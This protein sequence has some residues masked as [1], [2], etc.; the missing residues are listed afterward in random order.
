MTWRSMYEPPDNKKRK[1]TYSDTEDLQAPSWVQTMSEANKQK[2]QVLA[3]ISLD[4]AMRE[5][6]S[7]KGEPPYRE[8]GSRFLWACNADG[9]IPV[10]D[11]EVAF[12]DHMRSVHNTDDRRM[13]NLKWC[14]RRRN[15]VGDIRN[16]IRQGVMATGH[17][18]L[19]V[20]KQIQ[21]IADNKTA[22]IEI[23]QDLVSYDRSR[24]IKRRALDTIGYSLAFDGRQLVDSV[25]HN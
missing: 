10:F 25:T 12:T 18:W 20:P 14:L 19:R 15:F 3:K 21:V 13:A 11:T 8:E 6:R 16:R 7:F 17:K 23:E 2:F 4:Q 9:C 1:R 22:D 24:P 5:G